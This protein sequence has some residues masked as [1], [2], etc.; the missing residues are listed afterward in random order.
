MDGLRHALPWLAEAV[1]NGSS[2]P[3]RE[4]MAHAALVSGMALANSGLGM[5][6]GVAAALGVHARVPH[7]AACALMLPV[8]LR[9]NMPA[10]AEDLGRLARWV[11]ERYVPLPLAEAAEAFAHDIARLAQRVG[12][13][14]RLSQVGVRPDQIPAI[15]RDSRGSSMSGNP[16]DLSDEELTRILEEIL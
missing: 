13:P 7:G 11:D 16:R 2:R 12:T 4:H 1:E 15:V 8:A 9:V 5:A 3:A 6:H 10:C 14:S